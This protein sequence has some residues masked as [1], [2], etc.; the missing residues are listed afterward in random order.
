MDE[1]GIGS[2]LVQ[3][4]GNRIVVHPKGGGKNGG[5]PGNATIEIRPNSGG[6]ATDKV[7]YR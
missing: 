7:R 2:L 3:M 5:T 1:K 6:R 4:K